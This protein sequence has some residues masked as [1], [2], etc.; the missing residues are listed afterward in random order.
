M[1]KKAIL[2]NIIILGLLVGFVVISITV[3]YLIPAAG[4]FIDVINKAIEEL[5]KIIRR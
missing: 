3:Y 1:N 2:I 5:I 4:S